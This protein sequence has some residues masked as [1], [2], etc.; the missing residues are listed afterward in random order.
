MSE[1]CDPSALRTLTQELPGPLWFV[2][3]E[4]GTAVSQIE[5]GTTVGI[6]Y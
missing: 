3:I 1:S 5:C 2:P 6:G 4:C